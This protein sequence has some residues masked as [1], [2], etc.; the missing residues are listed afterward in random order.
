[1]KTLIFFTLLGIVQIV[2]VLYLKLYAPQYKEAE[3]SI[4]KKIATKEGL[5][6]HERN[7]AVFIGIQAII[8]F[9]GLFVGIY[10]EIMAA[11]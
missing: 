10:F 5:S 4:I 3:V 8:A 9:V 11:H 7:V 6:A 2:K 1:M